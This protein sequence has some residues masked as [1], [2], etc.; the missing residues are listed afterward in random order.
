MEDIELKA[1]VKSVDEILDD[2]C[3]EVWT[4]EYLYAQEFDSV[5]QQL[6]NQYSH[7][8]FWQVDDHSDFLAFCRMFRMLNQKRNE[9]EDRFFPERAV[10]RAEERER[11]GQEEETQR[12]RECYDKLHELSH[13]KKKKK[14]GTGKFS[15]KNFIFGCFGSTAVGE[16]KTG[17]G[18]EDDYERKKQI[19]FN[20]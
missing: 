4:P 1:L 10:E 12:F 20:Y 16:A 14:N 11:V 8:E 13:K 19:L 17:N 18:E 3:N 9:L 7:G 6:F 5:F 15:V 2:H